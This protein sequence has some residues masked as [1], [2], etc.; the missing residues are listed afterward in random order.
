MVDPK[1][2][3]EIPD[4]SGPESN[5]ESAGPLSSTPRRDPELEALLRSR[6][7]DDDGGVTK[8]TRGKKRPAKSRPKTGTS[9]DRRSRKSKL[10]IVGAALAG[11]LLLGGGGT[12]LWATLSDGEA[13]ID[14]ERNKSRTQEVGTKQVD[15]ETEKD[16]P[17][18]TESGVFPIPLENWQTGTGT[19]GLS[20]E[21]RTELLDTLYGSDLSTSASI[22]PSEAAG[23]TSDDLKVDT[24]D[25]SLNPYY[26]YWTQESFTADSGQIIEK[27]LNP[28]F[29]AWERYQNVG[30]DPNGID[31]A[32]LFPGTFTDDMLKSSEP[33]VNWLPIYADWSNDN[34]GRSDLASTGARWYGE[35]ESSTSKFVFDEATSQ[36]TVNFEANVK[37]T[38]Y[39]SSGEKVSEKGKLSL[40]FVANPGGERG[41][42]GKVLVNRSNLT[43]GG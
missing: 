24:E 22:L 17:F 42:G 23:F 8:A 3:P 6:S 12:A 37:F 5:L 36:Y 7:S 21:G 20:P 15:P 2:S 19:Q 14:P 18:N 28:R 25:G 16:A 41:S 39:E 34:Y 9:L 40:E 30:F 29:G 4:T 27:F 32:E 43:I 26:S 33:V 38:A 11:V 10:P 31:P 13:Q 35:V 1:E